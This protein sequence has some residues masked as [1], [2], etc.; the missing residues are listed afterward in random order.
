MPT[1]FR[2]NRVGGLSQ[3]Q[4][5]IHE[6]RICFFN[7]FVWDCFWDRINVL[8]VSETPATW[9]ELV[10]KFVS[11]V[12]GTPQTKRWCVS[13]TCLILIPANS[14]PTIIQGVN[15]RR[16]RMEVGVLISNLT[17]S[18][19]SKICL[20]CLTQPFAHLDSN[21]QRTL[22]Q[23]DPEWENKGVTNETE[24]NLKVTQAFIPTPQFALCW[25]STTIFVDK[26]SG[27]A[28]CTRL[29]LVYDLRRNLL[30]TS[31]KLHS[32]KSGRPRSKQV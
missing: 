24:M 8:W 17:F 27:I 25:K 16:T 14:N 3:P 32:W 21:Q 15:E 20:C 23:H 31:L 5:L 9:G 2:G 13:V 18:I 11:L 10:P 30:K 19:F 12:R 6:F 29:N 1:E 28:N 7:H 22:H 4:L 26:P